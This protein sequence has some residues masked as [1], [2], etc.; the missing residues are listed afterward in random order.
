MLR[1]WLRVFLLLVACALA[2]WPILH[3]NNGLDVLRIR[4]IGIGATPTHTVPRIEVTLA[5]HCQ[6]LDDLLTTLTITPAG[7]TFSLSA[8][9]SAEPSCAEPA[10]ATIRTDDLL[11]RQ[12]TSPEIQRGFVHDLP[13]PEKDAVLVRRGKGVS[14]TYAVRLD[15]QAV[16][17]QA[18][19]T[20]PAGAF[21]SGFGEQ[22]AQV[23]LIA[24]SWACRR[25]ADEAAGRGPRCKDSL[26][27]NLRYVGTVYEISTLLPPDGLAAGPELRQT[28]DGERVKYS[29]TH[30]TWMGKGTAPSSDLQGVWAG[31]DVRLVDRFSRQKQLLV[32]VA[33]SALLGA[34][35]PVLLIE[36]VQALARCVKFQV[37]LFWPRRRTPLI[38]SGGELGAGRLPGT[39]EPPKSGPPAPQRDAPVDVSVAPKAD[40]PPTAN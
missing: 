16:G 2:L 6:T 24:D 23:L 35:M 30:L 11:L 21:R 13:P 22:T 14:A 36:L 40:E 32:T 25:Q 4:S 5:D 8:T 28:Q 34:L 12:I 18:R 20:I 10:V 1:V 39:G 3:V 31:Y 29:T 27:A 17:E 7:S 26:R 37:A 33:F 38:P 19:Y 15:Q 9:H